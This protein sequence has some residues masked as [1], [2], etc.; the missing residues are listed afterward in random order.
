MGRIKAKRMGSS[1]A[2]TPRFMVYSEVSGRFLGWEFDETDGEFMEEHWASEV[3]R[4]AVGDFVELL[5]KGK[6]IRYFEGV[7]LRGLVSSEAHARGECL[8]Q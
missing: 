5:D 7:T 6:R 8:G 3:K 1:I 2:H 4:C